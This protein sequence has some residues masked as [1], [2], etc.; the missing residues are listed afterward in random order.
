MTILA[1]VFWLGF[2]SRAAARAGWARV[3][4]DVICMQVIHTGQG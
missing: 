2:G 3:P 1:D 4:E